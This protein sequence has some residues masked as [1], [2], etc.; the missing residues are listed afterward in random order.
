MKNRETRKPWRFKIIGNHLFFSPL[1][2]KDNKIHILNLNEMKNKPITTLSI[3]P[4]KR[5]KTV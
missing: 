4:I 5:S 1:D 3:P 2:N